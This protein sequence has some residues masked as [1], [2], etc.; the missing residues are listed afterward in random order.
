MPKL[1]FILLVLFTCRLN[2]QEHCATDLE[3]QLEQLHDEDFANGI[4]ELNKLSEE[5]EQLMTPSRNGFKE[6]TIPVVVHVVY[7]EEENN[8]CPLTAAA[9]RLRK[10]YPTCT[11]RHSFLSAFPMIVPSLSWQNDAFNI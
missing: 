11:K 5:F 9:V 8:S 4:N 6:I 3:N 7:R 1:V 10:A 2:A